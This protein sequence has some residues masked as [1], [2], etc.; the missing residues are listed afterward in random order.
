M[1]R[2]N[3]SQW[4]LVGLVLLQLGSCLSRVQGPGA[5]HGSLS[6]LQ[7]VVI[8]VVV[9]AVGQL[10]RSKSPVG[11][12]K[13]L[14]PFQRGLAHTLKRVGWVASAGL[15]LLVA[16]EAVGT[17]KMPSN[18]RWSVALVGWTALAAIYGQAFLRA[19]SIPAEQ[20]SREMHV[21]WRLDA[22]FMCALLGAVSA[23]HAVRYLLAR[24][25]HGSFNGWLA[26]SPGAVASAV[27]A[28]VFF[29]AAASLRA[30]ARRLETPPL[31]PTDVPIARP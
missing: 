15:A 23:F 6:I 5:D 20:A 28:A 2:L 16:V 8:L 25:W 13:R 17:G 24:P 21:S 18:D 4:F 29:F 26:D 22:G 30:R 19:G 3:A 9:L 12:E 31:E 1:K 27:I 7:F 10:F 14:P 11:D